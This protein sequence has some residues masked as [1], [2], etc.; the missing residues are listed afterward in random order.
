MVI[1]GRKTMGVAVTTSA[2]VV[3]LNGLATAGLCAVVEE[4]A[5]STGHY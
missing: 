4:E 2:A 1:F 3:I 5:V